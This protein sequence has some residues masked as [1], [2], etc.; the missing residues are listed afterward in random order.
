[1]FLIDIRPENRRGN[2]VAVYVSEY[3]RPE[4]ADYLIFEYMEGRL[5]FV[6]AEWDACFLDIPRID[7]MVLGY[8]GAQ[9]QIIYEVREAEYQQLKLVRR[10]FLSDGWH[11][12]MQYHVIDILTQGRYTLLSPDLRVLS[13]REAFGQENL[14][15]DLYFFEQFS[16]LW[17]MYEE[18]CVRAPFEV[19]VLGGLSPG[20]TQK[21][22]A[23][24]WTSAEIRLYQTYAG[25][26]SEDG[27]FPL[28][29]GKLQM[30]IIPEIKTRFPEVN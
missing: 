28:K 25:K 26:D 10:P 19:V 20:S 8:D 2:R 21:T 16:S 6:G 24:E 29:K 27:V 11:C 9:D 7:F 13:L 4:E 12:H 18:I 15:D 3:C 22:Y 14:L 17:P 1:D 30:I 23:I 5:L